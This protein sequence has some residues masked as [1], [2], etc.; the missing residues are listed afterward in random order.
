M[1]NELVSHDTYWWFISLLTGG[2]ATYWIGID[3]YRLKKALAGDCADPAI[4]DRIFGIDTGACHGMRLTG[5]LLPELKL[6]SVPARR[7]HWAEVRNAWQAPVLRTLPWA[8]MTFEQIEK[9]V[10]S[11][12]D[13][14]LDDSVLARVSAW[15]QALRAAVPELNARLDA[16]V[17]R[18]VDEAGAEFGRVA[19]SLR[20]RRRAGGRSRRRASRGW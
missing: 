1:N 8:G 18:I 13:P 15:T 17:L 19:A 12:R 6:I 16:E 10:R 11:L 3:S 2:V 9:K 20:N 7:D 5:L 4:R 14:E